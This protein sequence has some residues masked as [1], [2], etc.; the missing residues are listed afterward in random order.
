MAYHE[1]IL[2]QAHI[3]G[4]M[5]GLLT[6]RLMLEIPVPLWESVLTTA[7]TT[8]ISFVLPFFYKLLIK[9]LYP[10]K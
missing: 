2:T 10:K 7:L 9:K 1:N 8:T 3:S 4:I 6:G 5:G